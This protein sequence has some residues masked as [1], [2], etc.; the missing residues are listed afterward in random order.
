MGTLER[1]W[2]PFGDPK[3]EKGPHGDPGPQMGT[4]L[5]A[6]HLSIVQIYSVKLSSVQLNRLQNFQCTAYDMI[7]VQNSKLHCSCFVF[8]KICHSAVCQNYSALQY[9]E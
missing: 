3:T 5:G 2:G 1:K 6:V 9:A 7:T 8:L 4:H